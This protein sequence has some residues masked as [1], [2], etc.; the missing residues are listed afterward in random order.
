MNFTAPKTAALI[1]L[2]AAAMMFAASTASANIFC[3]PAYTAACP[4]DGT[5]IERSNLET[6]MGTNSN[7]G[8]ADTIYIG[9]YTYTDADTLVPT[10][11]DVLTMVG[12]G[13][14]KTILTSSANGN[15]FVANLDYFGTSRPTAMSNLTIEIPASFPDTQ[16]S[17]IQAKESTFDHVDIRSLNPRSSAAPSLLGNTVWKNSHF[18]GANGGS[19]NFGM[20]PNPVDSGRVE[21]TGVTID[22]S[23]RAIEIVG[24]D[25]PVIVHETRIN[26]PQFYGIQVRDGGLLAMENSIIESSGSNAVEVVLGNDPGETDADV[27]IRTSTFVAGPAADATDRA[28][29]VGAQ[30]GPD[31]RNAD[32][33]VS[34]S[35]L[36]GFP[37][38][39]EL[40]GTNFPNSGVS[41]L[42]LTNSNFNPVGL[43]T[44]PGNK[45][46]T[47]DTDINQDPKFVSPTDFHLQPGSPSIDAGNPE[48]GGI[49]QDFEG[50]ARPQDGNGDGIARRDQGA[51][52]FLAPVPTCET[53]PAVCPD[54]TAPVISKVKFKSAKGKKAG[55]LMF[56]L[57]EV[58]KVKATFKPIPAQKGKK[59]RKTVKL[60]LKGKAGKN[61]LRIEKGKLKPGRYRVT[62][63]ATDAA[64]NRS[65]GSVRKV[66]ISHP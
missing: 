64:G 45:V 51:Y 57:S 22:D 8:N 1:A 11:H 40:D 23:Q 47:N 24:P 46:L 6:A 53:T 50:T 61:T 37:N 14:D 42:T 4:N 49:L 27:S 39:W 31:T 3:V 26:R 44:G 32:I 28:I 36:A 16:G 55:S 7:D 52:E 48:P 65:K 20:K 21:I 25:N 58:A 41:T 12:S 18:Y 56:T 38:T 30:S 59:K 19:I 15:G 35:I 43:S 29:S 54:K 9:A 5:N 33:A 60:S 63:I 34:D 2:T 62:V 13:T 17:G 10:G 66:R